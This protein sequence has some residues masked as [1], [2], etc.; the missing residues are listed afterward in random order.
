M[1]DDIELLWFLLLFFL[2][3][4]VCLFFDENLH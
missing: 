1:G 2:S 4:F 3:I